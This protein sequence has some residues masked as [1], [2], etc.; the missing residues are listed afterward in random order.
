[1]AMLNGSVKN[2]VMDDAKVVKAQ[3]IG[4]SWKKNG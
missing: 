1:M 4:V 3:T 2:V